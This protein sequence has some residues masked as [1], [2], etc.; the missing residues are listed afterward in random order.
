MSKVKISVR[1]ERFCNEW[2]KIGV[3]ARAALAAGYAKSSASVTACRLL[4]KDHIKARIEELS[5]DTARVI[6]VTPAMLANELKKLSFANIAD[7]RTSWVKLEDF[8][9]LSADVKA[10]IS[11]IEHET[12]TVKGEKVEMVKI[13]MHNKVGAIEA[14][15]KMLGFNAPD[16]LDIETSVKKVGYGGDE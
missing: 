13:K 9:K 4:E 15:N 10:A 11:E 2:L 6:G 16:K 5:N 12:K 7:V 1:E 3:G 14:L 8:N